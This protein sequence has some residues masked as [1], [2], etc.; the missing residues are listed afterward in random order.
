MAD[1]RNYREFLSTWHSSP[2]PGLEA[3]TNRNKQRLMDSG[4]STRNVPLFRPF[5]LLASPG[6][7]LALLQ[8]SDHKIGAE[9]VCGA[10]EMFLRHVDFDTIYV[11]FAGSTEVETEFGSHVMKPGHLMFI[12]QGIA[13]RSTGSADSLRYWA[14][15]NDPITEFLNDAD[16]TSETDFAVTRRNGPGWK[17]PA[18]AETAIKSGRVQEKMVS[19]DDGPDDR[20]I[21]NRRYDDLVNVASTKMKEQASG[22][23]IIRIFD[24][25]SS[26]AGKGAEPLK[27]LV[28]SRYMRMRTYNIIGEQYAA[29]RALRS[30]EVRLHF[31]GRSMDMSELGPNNMGPGDATLIPRGIAHSVITTPPD[32]QDFLRL[33]FY[34]TLRWGYPN[35]LTRHHFNSSFEVKT[36][37]HRAAAWRTAAE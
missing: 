11:Q 7:S 33:N 26:I 16:H 15:V 36:T 9:S 12:P 31:R 28:Q 30:E 35:D 23:R 14:H 1:D 2:R 34:T 3:W 37:E 13:H 8:N 5:D 22:I 32:A 19:W 6:Q 24:V 10:Q 18:G 4:T 21:I 25:F 27:A 29:H 20:T 17:L